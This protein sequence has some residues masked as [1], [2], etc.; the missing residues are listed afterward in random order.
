MYKQLIHQ[1]FLFN[2][3]QNLLIGALEDAYKAFSPGQC[4]QD[5]H[6]LVKVRGRG[7]DSICHEVHQ[8]G[9]LGTVGVCGVADKFSYVNRLNETSC[10]HLIAGSLWV[11]SYDVIELWCAGQHRLVFW[12]VDWF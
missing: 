8:L 9:C 10:N 1:F 2:Q 5:F 12:G 11:L 4:F 3:L 6:K 7:P